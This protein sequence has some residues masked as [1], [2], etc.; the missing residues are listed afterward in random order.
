M[1]KETK[2]ERLERLYGEKFQNPPAYPDHF[3]R[4]DQPDNP[5]KGRS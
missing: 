3:T 1:K 5:K 4:H 2:Q